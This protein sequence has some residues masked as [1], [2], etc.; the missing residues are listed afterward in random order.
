VLAGRSTRAD[1]HDE[2]RFQC[3]R[4]LTGVDLII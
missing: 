2:R 1:R 3:A 4:P